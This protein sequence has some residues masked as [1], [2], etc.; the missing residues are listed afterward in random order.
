MPLES[1]PV[2]GFAAATCTTVAFVRRCCT[3]GARARLATFHWDVRRDDGGVLMWFVYGLILHDR[4]LIVATDHVPAEPDHSGHEAEAAVLKGR[5][6]LRGEDSNHPLEIQTTPRTRTRGQGRGSKHC[7]VK[8]QQF[9]EGQ[10]WKGQPRGRWG[11]RVG[12]LEEVA[13]SAVCSSGQAGS[14]KRRRASRFTSGVPP[15][16]GPRPRRTARAARA[17]PSPGDR[18]RPA[19]GPA[20]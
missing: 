10:A 1:C 9:A 20:S 2:L 12:D 6:G 17:R 18:P 14:R 11:A 4:P 19:R 15:G 5:R 3:S 7:E 16:R 8:P 13:Q